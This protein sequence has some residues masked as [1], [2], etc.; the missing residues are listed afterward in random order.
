[1]SDVQCSNS[2]I[3]LFPFPQYEKSLTAV[4]NSMRHCVQVAEAFA[5]AMKQAHP[6]D[7]AGLANG[8][9]SGG[10]MGSDEV[11]LAGGKRK[12]AEKKLKDPNAPKRPASAYIM[13]QNEIRSKLKQDHPELNNNELMAHISELWGKLAEDQKAVSTSPSPHPFLCECSLLNV[14]AS[15]F[16]RNITSKLPRIRRVIRLSSPLMKRVHPSRSLQTTR[17]QPLPS[18]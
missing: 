8:R 6:G 13:F 16:C 14:D 9:G 1:M 5:V 4:A 18:L 17:P 15:R 10:G 3:S 11:A 12:R 2:P 7:L